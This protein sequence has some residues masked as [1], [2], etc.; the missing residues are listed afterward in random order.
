MAQVTVS[1]GGFVSIPAAAAG[2]DALALQ[3]SIAAAINS[4]GT[5]AAANYLTSTLTG[6]GAAPAPPGTATFSDAYINDAGGQSYTVS[7]SYEAVLY[8]PTAADTVYLN[9]NESVLGGTVGGT[10]IGIGGDTLA[11]GGGN[12]LFVSSVSGSLLIPSESPDYVVGGAGNDTMFD[13]NG[14]TLDGGAGNNVL[15]AG[16]DTVGTTFI[17]SG[18]DLI[19]GGGGTDF[20][21]V[22]GANSTLLGGIG[23]LNVSVSGSGDTIAGMGSTALNVTLTGS[24]DDALGGTAGG[25]FAV[26]D[27]GTSDTVNAQSAATAVETMGGSNGYFYGGSGAATVSAASTSAV[28]VGGSGSLDFLGNGSRA[29][30]VGALGGNTSIVGSSGG[31][32]VSART[33][34]TTISGGT[35]AVTLFGGSGG[36]VTF[37]DTAHQGLF[38]LAGAGNETLDA[39]GSNGND[40]LFGNT[41]PGANLLMKAGSGNDTI[42]GGP[43]N[44]TMVAGSGK[45]LFVFF[46]GSA[47]G[48]DFINGLTAN[49]TVALVG[50]NLNSLASS[51]QN[52]QV[53]GQGVKITLSDNTSITFSGLSSLTGQ[54]IT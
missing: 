19:L 27:N 6:G 20:A 4:S 41:T 47:G 39:S 30:V 25:A 16:S 5:T 50:Y 45:D 10:F 49:D 14:G 48:Q 44:D 24:Q 12:N 32:Q 35:G 21:T 26:V 53:T 15:W 38:Y 8:N 36:N 28:V 1:S 17:S 54:N 33:G 13:G 40:S 29:T 31:L 43:G 18:T 37:T 51:L 2:S 3:T 42:I 7:S 52:A 9:P 34:K 11:L 46:N 22:S 23:I